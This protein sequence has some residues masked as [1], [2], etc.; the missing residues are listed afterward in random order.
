MNEITINLS[1]QDRET[2]S[3]ILKALEGMQNCQ[4]CSQI[5]S[6]YAQEL[7]E[8]HSTPEAVKAPYLPIPKEFCSDGPVEAIPT[9]EAPEP[10]EKP[11]KKE[12]VQKKVVELSAAGKKGEV[13]I[14]VNAYAE[15]VSDIPDDKLAEVYRKLI[16]LV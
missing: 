4:Q 5:S 10:E 1:N 3:K 13:K 15:R 9:A 7:K 8:I 16:E 6:A 2:L 12:D 11:I 14:I